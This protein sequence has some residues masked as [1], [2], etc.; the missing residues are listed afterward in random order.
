MSLWLMFALVCCLLT[1]FT[2]L[3]G[4]MTN[5]V[6]ASV[7]KVEN[8][9][10]LFTDNA[11]GVS[12]VDGYFSL[13]MGRETA[14]F[15]GDVFLLNPTSPEKSWLGDVSNCALLTPSGKGRRGLAHF[16]FLTNPQTHVARPMIANR[17]DEDNKTRFWPL[18]GYYDES[19]RTVFLYYMLVRFTGKGG[20]LDFR[21]IGYGLAKSDAR[22]P[23]A[24]RFERLK[25]ADGGELWGRVDDS[26]MFGIAVVTGAP[27]TNLYVLGYREK[28]GEH[29]AT[30][31]RV[32]KQRIAESEA[33]EYFAG[34]AA[35]PRWSSKVGDATDIAGLK[36][37]PSV[38][39][40][41]WNDYLGGYLAVH[42]VGITEQIQ[43]CLA[44]DPWGPYEP[45]GDIYGRHKAFAKGFCYDGAEH[46]ELAEEKGR[47][48]YVT[49]VDSDRYWQQLYKVTLQNK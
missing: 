39:S 10:L 23:D 7:A 25:A 15:F 36:N 31:A 3:A 24:M 2:A 14:W 9:G 45:I 43:L 30:L 38:L 26:P 34:T 35:S 32:A 1:A 46:P 41:S 20:P 8:E 49:F 44:K 6:H 27:G 17:P 5:D 13:P 4:D 21:I 33:Y 42:Q 28:N 12:G 47:I 29:P 22:N 40:V 19:Q 37:I 16:H 48:I 11:E 18:A